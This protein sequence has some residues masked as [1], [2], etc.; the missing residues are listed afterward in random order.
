MD[1]RTRTA[2]AA[3]QR[4]LERFIRDGSQHELVVK[5]WSSHRQVA[6]KQRSVYAM[7]N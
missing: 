2:S 4:K 7:Y 1:F 5:H 3:L 6:S